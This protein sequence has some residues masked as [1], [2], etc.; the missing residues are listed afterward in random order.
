MMKDWTDKL[1][2]V[3]MEERIPL[4]DGDWE[5]MEYL[6]SNHIRKTRLRKTA[7]FILP[8]VA[9]LAV[10][11]PLFFM[12]DIESEGDSAFVAAQIKTQKT[13]QPAI[14]Q[15]P[16]DILLAG[17]MSGPYRQ[18]VWQE[19]S[20]P[21]FEQ[22]EIHEEQKRKPQR[23]EEQKAEEPELKEHAQKELIFVDLPDDKKRKEMLFRI[24]SSSLLGNTL[25][26][27]SRLINPSPLDI[28]DTYLSSSDPYP[29]S[30][31]HNPPMTIG[32]SLSYYL[33]DLL[34]ATSGLDYSFCFSRVSLSDGTEANQRVHYLGL[35]LHLDWV[36]VRTDKIDLYVGAGA[37]VYRSIYADLGGTKIQDT[38][39]YYSAI[40][41][42]G[43]RFEPV[44]NVGL[45]VEPQYSF[46][47]AEKKPKI[48][49]AITD[50]RSLF[51]FKVGISLTIESE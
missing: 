31:R 42:A 38:N 8:V 10:E 9:I 13:H 6:L 37:K 21:Q 27:G 28:P 36:P 43:L 19:D 30:Y 4:P 46:N 24:G 39:F 45:F 1:K 20:E 18:E 16:E 40:C 12:K 32:L 48:H 25:S 29:L 51:S 5:A 11:V 44:K 7:L 3:L 15:E 2:E 41:L 14:V 35:P 26:S 23:Q 33:S 49:S 50:S 34:L 17:K 22:E 47:L